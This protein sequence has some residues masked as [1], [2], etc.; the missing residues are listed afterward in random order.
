MVIFLKGE[1]KKSTIKVNKGAFIEYDCLKQN[2][3]DL[4]VK[5]NTVL[6]YTFTI[7][8]QYLHNSWSLSK[9]S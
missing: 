1:F 4:A 2:D 7:L 6:D 8:V 3:L 5:R 9:S